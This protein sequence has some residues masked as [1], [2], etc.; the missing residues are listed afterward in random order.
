MLAGLCSFQRLRGR[1]CRLP[2][3]AS[4]GRLY[5]FVHD[6]L[7]SSKPQ[8]SYSGFC[9]HCHAP[10]LPLLPLLQG[11]LCR[12]LGVVQV[13]SHLNT[14]DL[15]SHIPF[16]L[17]CKVTCSQVLGTRSR[18]SPGA[19][20]ACSHSCPLKQRGGRRTEYEESQTGAHF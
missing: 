8:L 15:I 19:P 7:L 2:F 10:S 5:S 17:P 13:I 11:R 4:R 14:L 18:C 9:F 20:S 3:P 12:A 1:L 16:R 6:P